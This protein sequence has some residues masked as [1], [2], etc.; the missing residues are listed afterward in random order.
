MGWTGLASGVGVGFD[1]MTVTTRWV[2]TTGLALPVARNALRARM[3]TRLTPNAAGAN[4]QV[5][6]SGGA[7]DRYRG[8]E[9]RGW[10]RSSSRRN[11]RCSVGPRE[12]PS[13]VGIGLTLV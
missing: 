6:T 9:K 2:Q 3:P 5:R 11:R 4:R 10:T 13:V 1:S 8:G 12:S 7:A